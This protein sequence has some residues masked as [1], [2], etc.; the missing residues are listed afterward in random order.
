M[1]KW[2]NNA[3]FINDDIKGFKYAH[4]IAQ[5]ECHYSTVRGYLS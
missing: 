4:L 3:V 5:C 2:L 1:F